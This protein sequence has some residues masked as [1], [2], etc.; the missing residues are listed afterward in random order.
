MT[1]VA[2]AAPSQ[3]EIDALRDVL[4]LEP[5]ITV[6]LHST[7]LE[8]ALTADATL[9]DVVIVRVEA[10]QSLQR[11]LHALDDHHA[12]AP[13]IVLC[14]VDALGVVPSLVRQGM[15]AL[16]PTHAGIRE[17]MAAIDSSSAGLVTLT[18]EAFQ[19]GASESARRL[20]EPTRSA[21]P[22][23]PREREILA[24]L[25]DGLGNKIVAARLGI[26]EHTVKTHVTSIFAKLGA[27][28]RAEAVAI[29][30]R[31]GLILL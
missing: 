5:H 20:V 22:L 19:G 31:Q 23:S 27:E 17:L 12:A 2:I 24:L 21:P 25:A 4:A 28:T 18:A 13:F 8:R 1:R 7:R 6:T 29:G 10:L 15:R 26:S 30:A 16:L 14:D 9:A 3:P 11:T